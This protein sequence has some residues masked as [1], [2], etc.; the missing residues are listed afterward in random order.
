MKNFK[1]E[2]IDVEDFLGKRLKL[3]NVQEATETEMRFSCPFPGHTSGD[4][5]PSA[6]MNRETTAWICH[7]CKRKGNA[8][9]FIADLFNLSTFEALRQIKEYYGGAFAD[10]E[11]TIE[12][13][14]NRYFMELGKPDQEPINYT[15][16]KTVL[17]DFAITPG[18]RYYMRQRGFHNEIVDKF[19]I[20][21]DEISERVAIPIF[22]EVGRLVGFKGRS[23]DPEDKPKYKVLGGSLYGFPR[24]HVG[25]VVFGI[26]KVPKNQRTAIICEGEL[27]AIAMHQMGYTNA[28]AAGGSTFTAIHARKIVE[29][30]DDAVLYFDSDKAGNEATLNAAK[31]LMPHMPVK[32]MPEHDLDAA[33]VLNSFTPKGHKL[34][35]DGLLSGAQH[36]LELMI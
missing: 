12:D 24:Y 27:N 14:I 35:I 21:Y 18:V 34:E 7:G 25:L 17:S 19:Q 2:K 9:T 22:D 32:V 3:R 6:Y 4:E 16:Q 5:N 29:R 31:L 23:I 26:D 13:E 30:F 28:I 36:M 33:D 11:T 20:G 10:P 1:L 8:V 15:L